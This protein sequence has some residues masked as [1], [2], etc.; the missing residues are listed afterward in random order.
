[1]KQFPIAQYVAEKFTDKGKGQYAATG[2]LTI[3]NDTKEVPI[4]FTFEQKDSGA[5]LKDAA[6]IK[7]LDFGVRQGDW[8]DTET[9]ANEVKVKF[10]CC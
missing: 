4:G 8:K 3:R 10:A 1:V 5:W 6:A 9:V 2:K 7:R